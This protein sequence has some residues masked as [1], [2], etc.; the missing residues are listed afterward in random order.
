[1]PSFFRALVSDYFGGG[2]ISEIPSRFQ[3]ISMLCEAENFASASSSRVEFV[4]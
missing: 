3:A 1:M 4:N 2:E